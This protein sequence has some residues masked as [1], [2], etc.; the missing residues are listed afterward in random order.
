MFDQL[1]TRLPS[2]YNWSRDRLYEMLAGSDFPSDLIVHGLSVRRGI[3]T[4][5]LMRVLIVGIHSRLSRQVESILE[6][7]LLSFEVV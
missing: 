4:I 1:N 3:I 5:G 7:I 2:S 6:D